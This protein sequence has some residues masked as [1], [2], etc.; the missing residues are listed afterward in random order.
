MGYS[1][2]ESREKNHFP[3]N[4]KTCGVVPVNIALEPKVCP[5]CFSKEVAEYGIPPLSA[6]VTYETDYSDRRRHE[7]FIQTWVGGKNFK[8]QPVIIF[9]QNAIV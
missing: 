5:T 1:G 8:F 9:V 2:D 3:F 6:E 4:C 7:K